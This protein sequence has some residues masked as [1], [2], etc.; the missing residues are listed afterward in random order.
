MASATDDAS[1]QVARL[2]AEGVPTE[3]IRVDTSLGTRGAR[4]ELE[5]VLGDLRRGD[6]LVVTRLDRLASSVLHLVQV[7]QRLRSVG[8]ELRSLEED[9][10]TTS[11]SDA[12]VLPTLDLLAGLQRTLVSASTRAGLDAA[13]ARG[14]RGGRPPRLSA[15][16]AAEAQRLYDQGRS[17]TEIAEKLDVP[18]T[19]V[20]GHLR[21]PT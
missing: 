8:A 11:D 17:V 6:V 3:R 15:E 16:A 12:G 4:P 7:G 20:Y 13:R 9:V 21:R 10:D 14:R 1:D 2:Q 18:R 5:A 19:T